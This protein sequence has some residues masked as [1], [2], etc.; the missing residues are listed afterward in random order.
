ML[1]YRKFQHN[2]P[3]GLRD[4]KKKKKK[5]KKKD[6]QDGGRGGHLGFWINM[7]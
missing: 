2:S 5:K 4:V 7:I 6:F 3:C 1:L